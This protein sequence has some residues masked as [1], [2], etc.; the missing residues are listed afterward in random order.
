VSTAAQSWRAGPAPAIRGHKWWTLA[1]TCFG[2]FMALLDV[3]IVNVALPTIGTD[4][5]TNLADLQ[6]VVN[7][8]VL[9]LAVFLVTAGRLGDIFGRKLMF[10]LGLGIFTLGSL[11]CGLAGHISIGSLDHAQVLYLARGLQGLGGAFL[12]PLSLAIIS[13]AFRGTERGAAI[14]IWGAVG[15]LATAIGPLVGGLLV[16][17][18][19][20]E[21]IF[22]I[23][24]PIGIV[25]IGVTLW[26]VQE[27]RDER[28]PRT[29]DFFGLITITVS[30]FC[31][32]VALI[33]GNDP[34]KGWTSP[35][36]LTLFAV[37][38]VSLV[39]FVLGE[40]RLKNPMVDPRLFK[41]I[42]YTGAGIVGFTLSAGFFALFFFLALYLQNS[43]GFSPL[44]T[45]L[46]F[47]P[48]SVSMFLTSPISGRLTDR[49]GPR[50]LMAGGMA[51]LTIAALLM[52]RITPSD[53]ANDWTVLLPGFVV[54]GLG[55]GLCLPPIATVAVGT[56]SRAR[57]GMA[58]GANGMI[59]QIG[60]AFGVAFLG[61]IL[62]SRF[63]GYLHDGVMAIVDPRYPAVARNATIDSIER[64]AGTIGGSTGLRGPQAA[65]YAHQPHFVDL[66]HIAHTAFVN[67]M[68]DIFRVA[69]V[70]LAI[71]ALAG[72]FL[73]RS[74]D[75]YHEEA[76][77]GAWNQ[78]GAGAWQDAAAQQAPQPSPVG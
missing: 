62:T 65:P 42:T 51:L 73:I 55:M 41:N 35:Y 30:A 43:L 16:E 77:A 39:A 18:A 20:W 48:L 69:A 31:L 34:D 37:S 8:Y 61:A 74:R 23:N 1:A 68:V 10:C 40:L 21:W 19:G 47:L 5:R 71:G 12:F 58:S 45:G 54:G 53:T 26:A 60:N 25:G 63:N 17:H 72:F 11:L 75:M 32:L 28:A 6:W 14:G 56:V 59:R 78:E 50:P 38:A 27:S 3:T 52:S 66:Q 7:A 33:Q 36:I 24:V 64:G 76:P 46:R 29:I 4:L 57:V 44:D 2:L 67:G 9:T 49:I 22:F 13:V 15:G 70:I